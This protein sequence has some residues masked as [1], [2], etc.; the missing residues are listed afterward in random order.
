MN[1]ED[2]KHLLREALNQKDSYRQLKVTNIIIDVETISEKLSFSKWFLISS[3][4]YSNPCFFF[5]RY[6]DKYKDIVCSR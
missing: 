3:D 2:N 5:E 4:P 1:Q 6:S